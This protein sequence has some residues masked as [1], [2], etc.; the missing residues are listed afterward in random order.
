MLYHPW[1]SER[2]SE[3]WIQMCD[4]ESSWL[5]SNGK[6]WP[7]LK[8]AYVQARK[9]FDRERQR[10]KREFW[11]KE[12]D[13]LLNE[14]ILEI[15]WE[16]WSKTGKKVQNT[17]REID[18]HGNL[19]YDS[20]KVIKRWQNE[21]VK[22]RVKGYEDEMN[23]MQNMNV[24]V[25]LSSMN[26]DIT[27][28]EVMNAAGKAKLAKDVGIDQLPS[29]TLKYGPVYPFMV[30]LFNYCFK[31]RIIPSAWQTGVINSIPKS[32]DKDM[33]LNYRCITLTCHIYV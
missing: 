31:C 8:S 29:G 11:K 19:T 16:I 6:R 21:S 5:G 15:Y 13:R 10:C 26:R 18:G 20:N 30:W 4:S 32:G 28:E 12:Q 2:L 24:D 3:L 25:D 14:Q 22:C 27:L 33:W 9:M 7:V 17:F 1:W 23:V